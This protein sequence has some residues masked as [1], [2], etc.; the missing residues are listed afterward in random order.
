MDILVRLES[1]LQ[2]ERRDGQECP[3]YLASRVLIHGC[4]QFDELSWG[5]LMKL[6]FVLPV[7]VLAASG[8]I[9]WW[10]NSGSSAEVTTDVPAVS[11]PAEAPPAPPAIAGLAAA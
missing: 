5:R 3:S 10:A 2:S 4:W 7:T 9:W 1:A 8:A 11:A 6:V